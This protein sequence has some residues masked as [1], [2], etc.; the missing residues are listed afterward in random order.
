MANQILK[1]YSFLDTHVTMTGPGVVALNLGA[2][3]SVAEEGIDIESVEDKNVMT[4]GADGAGQHSLIASDARK[5]TLRFLKTSPINAALMTIYNAQSLSSALWGQN[6]FT[7]S[8]TGLGD[9]TIGQGAAFKKVP[10]LKY[11]K[12]AGFFEW[13]F[14]VIQGNSVLGA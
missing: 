3:A 5:V 11:A 13:E 9:V 2:G 1:S 7:V 6:I 10:N 4:I 12:E 8:N 14:D